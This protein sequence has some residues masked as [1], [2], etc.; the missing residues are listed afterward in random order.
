MTCHPSCADRNLGQAKEKV[1]DNLFHLTRGSQVKSSA[2]TFLPGISAA[3]WNAHKIRASVPVPSTTLANGPFYD[4]YLPWNTGTLEHW[5]TGTPNK[6]G[7]FSMKMTF[8]PEVDQQ[9]ADFVG[10]STQSSAQPFSTER[11]LLTLI[12]WNAPP[13]RRDVRRNP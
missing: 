12:G 9:F 1:P 6:N 5:N 7:I 13:I 2:E 8:E 4:R 3:V 10:F 11:M